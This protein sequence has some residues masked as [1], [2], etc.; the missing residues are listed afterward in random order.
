MIGDGR[1]SLGERS[2]D[3]PGDDALLKLLHEAG[4]CD[5]SEEL[6]DVVNRFGVKGL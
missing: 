4:L 1:P 6:V 5:P 3:R 2:H